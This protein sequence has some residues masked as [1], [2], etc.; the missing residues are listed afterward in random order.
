MHRDQHF[1]RIAHLTK[2][3]ACHL[4]HSKLGSRAETVLDAP[5]Q[6]V[7]APV[8]TFELQDHIHDMFQYLRSGNASFLG[9]MTDQDDRHTCFLSKT[10][11]HRG[12][13]LDLCDRAGRRLDILRK[14]GLYR[15]HNHKV[16]HHGPGFGN[17]VLHQ[18]LAVYHA[19]GIVASDTGCPQLHLLRAL[20][21]CN[22]QGLEIRAM[23]RNLQGQGGFSDTRLAS[24]QDQRTFHQSASENTVHFA[25]VQ[26][27]P[28]LDRRI[29]MGQRHRLLS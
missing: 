22:I 12:S 2:T 26:R 10:Q 11:E 25:V 13:L 20:L 24:Y 23:K 16:R 19:S 18:G 6:T 8:V 15:V 14:H 7:C 27:Y 1:R 5:E 21:S 29:D 17:Y 3:L 9:D 4:E 28:V